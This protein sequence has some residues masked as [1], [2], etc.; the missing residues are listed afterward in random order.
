[1]AVAEGAPMLLNPLD[2]GRR[3]RLGFPYA[4]GA[5]PVVGHLP[6]FHADL[7]GLAR[8]AERRVGSTFWVDL[9]FGNEYLMSLSPEVFDIFR[10][11]ST[12]VASFRAAAGGLVADSLIRHEGKTHQRLR[13]ALG[14]PFTPKGLGA[15]EMGRAFAPIITER[16]GR[17]SGRVVPILEETREMVLALLFRLLGIE[18]PNLD[19]WHHQFERY[20]LL[21]LGIPF[22]LPG[23]P[24]RRALRAKAWIDARLRAMVA[25]ARAGRAPVGVIA[26]LANARDEE[27]DPL[28]EE[29]LL[30]NLRVLVLAGHETT[31]TVLAWMTIELGRHPEAWSRLAD[32]CAGRDLPTSP[33]DLRNFPVAEAVFREALRLHTPVPFDARLVTGPLTIDGRPI[34][35]GVGVAVCL[36][37]LGRHPSLYD[38]PDRFRPERWLDRP[39]PLAPIDTLQFGGGPHFCLGYHLAL[40]EG[41]MFAA[42]LARELGARGRQPRFSGPPPRKRYLPLSRPPLDITV[43]MR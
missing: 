1:M 16:V 23:F 21:A 19:E 29:D 43:D 36:A 24:R 14:G 18:A 13:A 35:E 31:A 2:D 9:G 11:R 30:G 22:D 20:T 28:A 17:W 37:H 6:A 10:D 15:M 33:K 38:D 32:E 3:A 42:A 5:F 4:P 7:L 39:K 34:P 26:A 27:G 40:L 12:S 41:V 25:G 8:H